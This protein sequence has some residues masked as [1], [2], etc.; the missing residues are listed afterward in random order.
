LEKELGVEKGKMA[1][2]CQGNKAYFLSSL[3]VWAEK[4][5]ENA[6]YFKQE[7]LDDLSAHEKGH[8]KTLA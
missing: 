3:I 4:K 1:Y 5:G 2:F 8:M 7:H 6:K